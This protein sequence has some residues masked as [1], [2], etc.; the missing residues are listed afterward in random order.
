[1]TLRDWARECRKC[2]NPIDLRAGD[3]HINFDEQWAEH[4]NCPPTEGAQ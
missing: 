3:C 4:I 2:G 1:M